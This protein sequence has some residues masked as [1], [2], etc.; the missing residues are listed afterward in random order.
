MTSD[1]TLV[2][3]SCPDNTPTIGLHQFWGTKGLD[4]VG[5]FHIAAPP[6][7]VE[8]TLVPYPYPGFG[9]NWHPWVGDINKDS[10]QIE[11]MFLSV[12]KDNSMHLSALISKSS[13][14]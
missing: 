9:N 6:C 7:I 12:M 14:E 1:S 13:L 8:S 5:V 4:L 2:L 11:C 10:Q 3:S